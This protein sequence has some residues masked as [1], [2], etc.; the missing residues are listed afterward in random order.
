MY[1]N[2]ND[3][4]VYCISDANL[5]SIITGLKEKECVSLDCDSNWYENKINLLEEKKNDI[6]IFNDRCIYKSIKDISDN[7]YL[8]TKISNTTIYSYELNS[9]SDEIKNKYS[10]LTYIDFSQEDIDF[11]YEYFNLDKEN[12]KIYILLSDSQSKDSRTATSDYNFIILLENG[13]QLNLSNINKDFYVDVSIPIRDLDLA[14]FDYAKYFEDQGYDIYNSSSQFYNDFCTSASTSGND[15]VLKDRKEDIYPNNVTFCKEGCQYKS[16][17]IEEQ[18][19]I[20]EC[21]LNNNTNNEEEEND[22]NEEESDDGNYFSYFIDKINFKIFKCYKVIHIDNLKKNIP[23]YII[24]AVFVIIIILSLEFLI[25]GLAN[26][27]IQMYKELPTEQK[28][29]EMII[30]KLKKIKQ[31]QNNKGNPSKKKQKA[32]INNKKNKNNENNTENYE[33]KNHSSR[34]VTGYLKNKKNSIK[35]P[36]LIFI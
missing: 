28:V 1:V 30:E 13:T 18:R 6:S 21:N 24:L 34:S 4:L 27:R 32:K 9:N 11:I 2:I 29:R 12:D 8:S 22:L 26:L 5:N 20:C 3:D 14:N 7:F 17:N 31:I 15:V 36:T 25:C 10:N 19:I 16:V 35:K 23:F 33:L